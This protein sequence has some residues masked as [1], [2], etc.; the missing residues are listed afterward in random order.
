MFLLP[1]AITDFF[2]IQNDSLNYNLS[3]GSYADYGNLRLLLA[4]QRRPLALVIRRASEANHP[5]GTSELPL[6]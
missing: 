6:T 4:R 2:G 1:G 5:T 3:V